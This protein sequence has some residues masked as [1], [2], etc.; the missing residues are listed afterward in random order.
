MLEQKRGAYAILGYRLLGCVR[1]SSFT[2]QRSATV[3]DRQLASICT[4]SAV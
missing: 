3:F 2:E 1:T 4:F